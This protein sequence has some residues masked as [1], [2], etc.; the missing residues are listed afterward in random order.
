MKKRVLIVGIISLTLI[1]GLAFADYWPLG[2]PIPN[3]ILVG[4]TM[5]GFNF[6]EDIAEVYLE[7]EVDLEEEILAMN[8]LV[9]FCAICFEGE[10]EAES[11]T[12]DP[13][14]IDFRLEPFDWMPPVSNAIYIRVSIDDLHIDMDLDFGWEWDCCLKGGEAYYGLPYGEPKPD[15][16]VYTDIRV[17]LAF[18]LQYVSTPE[19]HIEGIIPYLD[20]FLDNFSFDISGIPDE[21]ESWLYGTVAGIVEDIARQEISAMIVPMLNDIL[22][23]IPLEDQMEFEVGDETE[24][25]DYYI[26]DFQLHTSAP[27]QTATVVL[28]SAIYFEGLDDCVEPDEDP[29]AS[30]YTPSSPPTFTSQSPGGYSYH[31]ALAASDDMVNQLL[32][33]TYTTGLLCISMTLEDLFPKGEL[34]KEIKELAEKVGEDE[35][36]LLIIVHPND[37]PRFSVGTADA[38]VE[39]SIEDLDVALYIYLCERWARQFAVSMDFSA[40]G[41]IDV[42]PGTCEEGPCT[43]ITLDLPTYELNVDVIYSELSG[44]D[45][46]GVEEL[47]NML[48]DQYLDQILDDYGRI[49]LPALEMPGGIYLLGETV[50]IVPIGPEGDY[51]GIFANLVTAE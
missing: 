39:M 34:P 40:A 2:E 25:L 1:L 15:V 50:E 45:D 49:E 4:I 22:S 10:L 14:Q 37:E 26:S 47:L 13:I 48:L 28:G 6:I 29:P 42:S 9:D 12:Y 43:I 27:N 7:N 31:A 41:A 46:E 44:M 8:P 33:S 17:E 5:G 30:W 11:V 21:L 32:Y 18:Q 23:Q 38:P 35:G 20:V 24:I 16:D 3:S 19:P 51:L 36:L